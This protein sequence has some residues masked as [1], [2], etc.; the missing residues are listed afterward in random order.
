MKTRCIIKNEQMEIAKASKNNPKKFWNYI[1]SKTKNSSSIGDIKYKNINGEELLA[2]TDEEKSKVFCDY[3]SSVFTIENDNFEP[4]QVKNEIKNVMTDISFN[5][6][7]IQ[8]RLGNL[9][10]NKSQ[11]PD[12]IHPKI[13]KEANEVLAKPLQKIFETSFKMKQIPL[14]WKTAD[15]SAIFKKGNKLDVG[16]Y[17][18]ISLTCICCKIMESII[19]DHIFKYFIDN[20]L[21][22]S[23]QFGFIKGR[24]TVLQLLKVLDSGLNH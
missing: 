8:L 15:I 21:F 5:A 10:V 19:R 23:N 17:R 16:N 11:G 14:D 7:D 13:L 3:F 18:P 2:T 6:V 1:K 20:K 24:S 12:N 9:N 22:S 4:L